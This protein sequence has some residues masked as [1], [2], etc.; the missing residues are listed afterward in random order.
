MSDDPIR[1]LRQCEEEIARCAEYEGPDELMALMGW[2]D[3]SIERELILQELR[4]SPIYQVGDRTIQII[5][6]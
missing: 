5:L 2:A 4:L 1:D 3:W 6:R